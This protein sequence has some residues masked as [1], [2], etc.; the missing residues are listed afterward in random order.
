MENVA[1]AVRVLPQFTSLNRVVLDL[2]ELYQPAFT[3]KRLGS[4][5]DLDPTLPL[6]WIDAPQLERGLANLLR[7]AVKHTRDGDLIVCR[8]SADGDWI[9]LTIGDNGPRLGSEEALAHNGPGIAA[10]QAI[11][12][13]HGGELVFDTSHDTGAWF[14]IRL[15]A[16]ALEN[17]R[18]VAELERGNQRKY[19]LLANLSYELRTPLNVIIGYNDL[20]LDGAFG[21]L[22]PAQTETLR[23]IDQGSRELLELVN[24]TLDPSC[25]TAETSTSL[26]SF[27]PASLARE[28]ARLMEELHQTQRAGLEFVTTTSHELRTPLTAIIGYND[29]M[30][31]HEF[32]PVSAEQTNV[33]QRVRT[34][35]L[36]LL[37][38][39]NTNLDVCRLEGYAPTV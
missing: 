35:A 14:V 22:A 1:S 7:T 15:P 10:S 2:I 13:A 31:D 26:S 16:I 39:I 34:S 6:T 28:N 37:H 9:E 5:L 30:L 23:R 3:L 12:A 38:A 19:D 29:L 32:G 24:R 36:E 11:V 18:L 25:L 17:A 4:G 21:S 27:E 33:L 8:T 20:L